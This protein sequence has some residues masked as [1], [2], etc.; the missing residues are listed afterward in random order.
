[1]V[2][3]ETR[4]PVRPPAIRRSTG[5]TAP[6]TPL[7]RAWTTR[8][9]VAGALLEEVRDDL[10]MSGGAAGLLTSVPPLCFA[11]FGVTAPRLARRFGPA[12]VVC[13]GMAA[14]AAGLA[15]RPFT[16]NAAGFLAAS[17]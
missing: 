14:I 9:M 8:L 3:E 16:G 10:G 11:V 7:P 15:I 6:A 1:M 17:A 12:A 5:G 2:P 4:T 13:A